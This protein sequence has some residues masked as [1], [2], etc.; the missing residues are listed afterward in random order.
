MSI[1]PKY[2][3][4]E[5]RKQASAATLAELIRPTLRKLVNPETGERKGKMKGIMK[6][7]T[8]PVYTEPDEFPRRSFVSDPDRYNMSVHSTRDSTVKRF[9]FVKD[10]KPVHKSSKYFY[11]PKKGGK[12]SHKKS[13][14]KSGKKTYKR[15]H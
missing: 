5:D 7:K 6:P 15:R 13:G 2:L 14:R 10:G 11:K 1:Y 9:R 4:E 12:K 8:Y 3:T